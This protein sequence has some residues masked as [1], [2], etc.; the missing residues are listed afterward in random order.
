MSIT[1]LEALPGN[2]VVYSDMAWA[3]ARKASDGH[4]QWFADSSAWR[5]SKTLTSARLFEWADDWVRMV[6]AGGAS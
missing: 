2:A 1:E 3:V 4:D 6:P 5:L